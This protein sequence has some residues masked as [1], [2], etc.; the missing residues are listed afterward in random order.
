MLEEKKSREELEKKKK[1][2]SGNP[3]SM[4]GNGA[5]TGGLGS[6][7]FGSSGNGKAA[8]N[9]FAKEEKKVEEKKEV[10]M[11]EDEESSDEESSRQVEES[12][13]KETLTT[14]TSSWSKDSKWFE[15]S[16]HYNPSYYLNTIPEPSKA[17]RLAEK[18]GGIE[19]DLRKKV[20]GLNVGVDRETKEGKEKYEQT[21][22]PG[23]DSIFEKFL[24][25]VGVEGRQVVRYEFDGIPLPFSGKGEVFDKLWPKGKG[26]VQIGRNGSNS[27]NGNLRNFNDEK[28]PKCENCGGKRVFECQLMPNLVNLLKVENIQLGE[29]EEIEDK[30]GAQVDPIASPEPQEEKSK[31]TTTLSK[32]EI[33]RK[34]IEGLLG[35]QFSNK[36]VFDSDGIS[37][38]KPQ[39]SDSLS[40]VTGLTWST[41]LV[42]VC[43]KDCCKDLKD[44]KRGQLAEGWREEWVGLMW[45][46]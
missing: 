22:I 36:P 7:L 32:E 4:S 29:D 6:S 41:A 9:P 19:E 8:S 23:L 33:R 24:K 2:E 25:R 34:E 15:T 46:D 14:T 44:E 27:I 40:P 42:F 39:V 21:Q 20:E 16:T 43:E 10:L 35:R 26:N 5:N 28:I 17:L 37:R 11:E 1:V 13:I 38:S 31:A 3:F 30:V 45:E 12:K 18:Q